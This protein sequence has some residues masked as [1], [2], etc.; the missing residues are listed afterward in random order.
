M[1][2]WVLAGAMVAAWFGP[3]LS[4]RLAGG[5]R[6]AR[7]LSA[8]AW[9]ALLPLFALGLLKIMAESFTPVLY[10]QF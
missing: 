9:L 3:W 6:L 5:G 7:A 8:N 4:A 10:A 1:A 2:L